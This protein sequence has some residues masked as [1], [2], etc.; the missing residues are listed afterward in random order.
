M[1]AVEKGDSDTRSIASDS[2]ST[3]GSRSITSASRSV[4]SSSGSDSDSDIRSISS[5]AREMAGLGF[6]AKQEPQDQAL[7]CGCLVA[8]HNDEDWDAIR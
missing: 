4:T 6:C 5:G 2:K 1:L 7:P 3:S 8:G